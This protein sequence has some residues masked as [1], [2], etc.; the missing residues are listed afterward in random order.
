[1]ANQALHSSFAIPAGLQAVAGTSQ[2]LRLADLRPATTDLARTHQVDL[3][4]EHI[5]ARRM[6]KLGVYR[7]I[8]DNTYQVDFTDLPEDDAVVV[9]GLL[10]EEIRQKLLLGLN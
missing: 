6:R 4:I 2:I 7:R 3:V 8:D 10:T 5:L 1:M 9:A